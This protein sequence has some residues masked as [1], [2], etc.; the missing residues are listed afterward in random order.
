VL[1]QLRKS[2]DRHAGCLLDVCKKIENSEAV[3]KKGVWEKD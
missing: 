3:G 2:G 1:K